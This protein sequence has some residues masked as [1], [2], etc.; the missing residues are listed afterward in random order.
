MRMSIQ[1]EIDLRILSLPFHRL[2]SLLFNIINTLCQLCCND[3]FAYRISKWTRCC[4]YYIYV[5]EVNWMALWRVIVGMAQREHWWWWWEKM[6]FSS[7]SKSMH[8]CADE[9]LI[10]LFLINFVFSSFVYVW[11]CLMLCISNELLCDQTSNATMN[12]R[13]SWKHIFNQWSSRTHWDKRNS[14]EYH[15]MFD[16]VQ[17]TTGKKENKL[18]LLMIIWHARKQ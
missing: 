3:S 15:R 10:R 8:S 14:F 6:L 16:R 2:S 9:L 17:W 18:R 4:L 1:F 7:T 5:N 11:S 13:W 12:E